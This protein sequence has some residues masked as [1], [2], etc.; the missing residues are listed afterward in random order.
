MPEDESLVREKKGL[1]NKD[2][3]EAE[4]ESLSGK[5][6]DFEK[7]DIE[8]KRKMPEDE[9]PMKPRKAFKSGQKNIKPRTDAW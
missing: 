2:R 9:F 5:K 7:I 8:S 1:E 6:K 4:D 3:V